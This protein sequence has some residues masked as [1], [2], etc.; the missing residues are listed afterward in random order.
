MCIR[1]YDKQVMAVS[2]ETQLFSL[3]V[4]D[5]SEAKLMLYELVLSKLLMTKSTYT[6]SVTKIFSH[7]YI[8]NILKQLSF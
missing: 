4:D 2:S 5:I 7:M 1:M 3:C 6:N 8:S